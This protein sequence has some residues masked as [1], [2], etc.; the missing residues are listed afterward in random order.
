MS[1]TK[2]SKPI[3]NIKECTFYVEGMHCSSCELLI[4]KELLEEK[5]IKAVEA[6]TSNGTVTIEYKGKKPNLSYLNKTFEDN[7][8]QFS[9][10]LKLSFHLIPHSYE[11]M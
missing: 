1:K 2:K 6:S 3:K 8:Y 11:S 5:S 10:T 4:E 9:S 7:N